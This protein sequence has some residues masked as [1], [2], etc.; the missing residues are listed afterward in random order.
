[1]QSSVGRASH[2]GGVASAKALRQ[3]HA[4]L[5]LE[6]Q[7]GWRSRQGISQGSTLADWRQRRGGYSQHVGCCKGTTSTLREGETRGGFQQRSGM[8]TCI[9]KAHP[10]QCIEQTGRGQGRNRS[11]LVQW[12]YQW[13]NQWIS[14]P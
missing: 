9:L 2:T 10:G 11:Q 4:R 14:P 7:G 3:E 1:M 5:V 12:S 8:L 13:I 6:H